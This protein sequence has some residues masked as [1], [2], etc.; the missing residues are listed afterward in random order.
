MFYD[1][2]LLAVAFNSN[3][4]DG[5]QQQQATLLPI[6]G[7]S[8]TGLF[9]AFQVFHGT[10]CGVQGSVPTVCGS[11]VT[12]GVAPSARYLYGQQRFDPSTF[13]GFGPIR[14]LQASIISKANSV[15]MPA[16]ITTN[17]SPPSRDTVSTA[18][19][20]PDSRSPAR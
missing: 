16:R 4:A 13:T 14:Y 20:T 17:S 18:R 12:P 2:P 5:S 6:G 9:N 10:V 7:P 8:P 11:T 15:A 3:I 19:I 1:H